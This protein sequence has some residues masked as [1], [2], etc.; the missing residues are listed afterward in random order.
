MAYVSRA[1]QGREAYL[2]DSILEL[3]C[4]TT[5]NVAMIR[6]EQEKVQQLED[7]LKH[8]KQRLSELEAELFALKVARS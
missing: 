7:N 3:K 8:R 1:D 4:M 5:I 2:E 6:L